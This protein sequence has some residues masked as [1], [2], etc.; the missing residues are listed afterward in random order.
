MSRNWLQEHIKKNTINFSVLA[1]SRRTRYISTVLTLRS[2]IRS[3]EY[4]EVCFFKITVSIQEE[5]LL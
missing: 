2:S 1:I 3:T 5:R 4:F